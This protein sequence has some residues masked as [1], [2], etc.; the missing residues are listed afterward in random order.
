[1][2]FEK[3]L[4]FSSIFFSLFAKS[5]ICSFAVLQ[6]FAIVLIIF[7]VEIVGGVLA[8][9]YLPQAR[10]LVSSTVVLYDPFND[11]DARAVLITQ[12]WDAIQPVVR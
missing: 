12:A 3:V 7:I 6:F 9:V 2:K 8:F 1:M 4:A 5:G 11:T 10:M